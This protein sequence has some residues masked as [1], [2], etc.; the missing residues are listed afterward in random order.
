[1]GIVTPCCLRFSELKG[2]RLR[3][4]EG[5][6]RNEPS[7]A[8]SLKNRHAFRARYVSLHPLLTFRLL[9]KL[10]GF[11]LFYFGPQRPCFQHLGLP[12]LTSAS[13]QPPRLAEKQERA[14]SLTCLLSPHGPQLPAKVQKLLINWSKLS[15]QPTPLHRDSSSRVFRSQQTLL[16]RYCLL[17][18]GISPKDQ[19]PPVHSVVWL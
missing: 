13:W 2:K 5:R 17:R 12:S 11:S 10:W 1:M 8:T 6:M 16:H 19:R 7:R 18:Q 3:R 14:L 4:L 9:W 15:N